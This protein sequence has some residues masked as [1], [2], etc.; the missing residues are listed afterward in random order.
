ML[1]AF[2]MA[3]RGVAVRVCR[4]CGGCGRRRSDLPLFHA[5]VSAASGRP[6]QGQ[7]SSCA[8]LDPMHTFGFV[9]SWVR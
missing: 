6:H 3:V 7:V 5:F 1:E 8:P 4:L 2:A 9:A